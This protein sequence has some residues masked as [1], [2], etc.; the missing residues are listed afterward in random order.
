M[1]VLVVED[2]KKVATFI[3]KGLEEEGYEVVVAYD[4]A[5]GLKI[6]AS[7]FD[8]LITDVMLRVDSAKTSVTQINISR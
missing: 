3:K 7:K 8:L 5:D 4:G 2:E 6:D 1:R